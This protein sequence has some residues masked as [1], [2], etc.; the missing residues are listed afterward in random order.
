MRLVSS[1]CIENDDKHAWYY[2]HSIIQ[3]MYKNKQIHR[4]RYWGIVVLSLA[5]FN[6]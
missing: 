3:T 2:L 4:F 1:Y 5:L 6:G